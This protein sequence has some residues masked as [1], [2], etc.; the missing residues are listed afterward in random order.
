MGIKDTNDKG[1]PLGDDDLDQVRGAAVRTPYQPR[2][3]TVVPGPDLSGTYTQP[4]WSET[5]GAAE[6][7]AGADTTDPFR[8]LMVAQYADDPGGKTKAPGGSGS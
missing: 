5:A 1:Q 3:E 4:I 7:T 8:N 2:S 6:P